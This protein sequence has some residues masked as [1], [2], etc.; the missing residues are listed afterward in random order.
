MT[1]VE[2]N[3]PSEPAGNH[4]P[5]RIAH[6]SATFP[7]YHGGTGNVCYYQARELARRG[8]SVHV[9]TATV[10]GSLS[11][12]KREGFTVH[13]LRPLL[14][15][16]NAFLLPGLLNALQGFDLV[17]LHYPFFGG[18]ITTLAARL[19]HLP[20]VITY[21][22]DVVLH[23]PFGLIEKAIRPTLGRVTLRSAR[24]L[25]FTSLDY[26]QSS[27][28][29][30][31]LKGRAVMIGELPNGVDTVTFRPAPAPATLRERHHLNPAD[32][33]A[34]LVAGLDPAHYFKGVNFFL[35]ALGR[36][37]AGYKAIIVGDGPLRATYEAFA[38]DRGLTGRVIFA[39]RVSS[40]DLPGY[41]RLAGVT[42]LP[43]VTR[44]EAFGLVL[45][46]SLACSTPVIASNLPGVRTVVEAGQDGL[47][48]EPQD[49]SALAAALLQIF[50][51]E[52]TRQAMGQAGRVKVEQRYAWPQ[53]AARLE[54][55]YQE[56]LEE[57]HPR[58]F[59]E[60]R[61]AR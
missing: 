47:L 44:G 19:K 40:E 32:K 2:Q 6:V 60:S 50:E 59:K 23:G 5:L 15:A 42:V 4:T 35:E 53:L 20:M 54:T 26:G 43:S 55:I 51:N 9:F 12:E 11:V 37:P 21:H 1:L 8:H 30:P 22:Q 61:G 48:V 17:H 27:Y 41:Y 58:A 49:A 10:P 13:R 31:L 29:R 46:E 33:V 18:E 56:V 24:R 38:V 28:I 3:L 39:G 45:L 52:S 16:G 36:L 14:K 57:A 34:L 7:P 25:L